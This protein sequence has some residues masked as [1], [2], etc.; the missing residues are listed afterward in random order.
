MKILKKITKLPKLFIILAVLALASIVTIVTLLFTKVWIE[1]DPLSDSL[2]ALSSQQEFEDALPDLA[3]KASGSKDATAHRN[4]AKALRVTGDLTKAIEEFL[5][6]YEIDKTAAIAADIA[7]TYR[8]QGDTSQAVAYY[9]ES[10]QI[11]PTYLTAVIQLSQLYESSGDTAASTAVLQKAITSASEDLIKQET[12][13]LQLANLEQR[14]GNTTKA[15]THYEKVL[16]LNPSNGAAKSALGIED[17][18]DQTE[19]LEQ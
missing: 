5:R 14:L 16:E 2:G 17:E 9:K 10:L 4:Y 18:A 7:T 3:K 12:L 19:P 6:A 1:K 8:D 15:T 13:Y 11:D